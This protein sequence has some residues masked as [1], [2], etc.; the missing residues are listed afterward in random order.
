[1]IIYGKQVCL[2]VLEKH[3]DIIESVYLSKE[4]DKKIFNKLVKTG[5]KIIKLDNKKAQALAKGGNHQGFFLEIKDFIFTPLKEMRDCSF[6]VVLSDITDTGNIGAIIRTAYVMGV[7][8]IIISGLKSIKTEVIARTSSGALFDMPVSLVPNALDMINELKQNGF[9]I[10]AADI[11]G[12]DI[13][14]I[15]FDKKRVLILGSEDKGISN[16]ILKK[17]DEIITIKQ[18]RDFNSLNVASAAAILCYR[19]K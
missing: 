16:K 8:G 13:E 17:A 19:M 7:E 18:K 15:I 10:Y 4:I 9:I 2:Y 5:K 14:D 6:L 12:K 3:F 11:K 1:M